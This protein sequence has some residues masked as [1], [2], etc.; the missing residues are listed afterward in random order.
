MK[1]L[2]DKLQIIATIF[3]DVRNSAS[4]SQRQI[5]SFIKLGTANV[6]SDSRIVFKS[7]TC[8]K[9]QEVVAD[10]CS[11]YEEEYK[12]KVNVMENIA[13]AKRSEDIMLHLCVWE[14]QLCVNSNIDL[15]IKELIAE[16]DLQLETKY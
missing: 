8:E 16:A 13:H 5:D 7:W 14:F 12:S 1:T 9:I 11:S 3:E 10:V 2:C 15:L 6:F 4:D